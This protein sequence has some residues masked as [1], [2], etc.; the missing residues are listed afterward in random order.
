MGVRGRGRNFG[1]GW[2]FRKSSGGIRAESI[3][4]DAGGERVHAAVDEGEYVHG[5]EAGGGFAEGF[6][7]PGVAGVSEE[8]Q[9]VS[10]AAGCLCS[11]GEVGGV[12]PRVLLARV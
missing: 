4:G 6:V 1:S 7:G 8:R 11:A 9:A 2:G 10:G 3:A 12:C 5:D